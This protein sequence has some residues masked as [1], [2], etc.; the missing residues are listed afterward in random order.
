MKCPALLSPICSN[1]LLPYQL[2][3]YFFMG[4][5]RVSSGRYKNQIYTFIY[6]PLSHQRSSIIYTIH[7]SCLT[8][9]LLDIFAYQHIGKSPQ[10]LRGVCLSVSEDH[11]FSAI[12]GKVLCLCAC[13]HF[14]LVIFNEI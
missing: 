11:E 2:L 14:P 5:S 8:I 7:V 3:Y 4:A 13:V 10:V 12:S 9:H 1:S 6:C